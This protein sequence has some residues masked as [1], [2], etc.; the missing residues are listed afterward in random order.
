MQRG[1]K[2]SVKRHSRNVLQTTKK[3]FNLI[4][5][6][7]DTILSTEHWNSKNSKP[8]GLHGKSKDSIRLITQL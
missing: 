3:S 4:N 5:S 1:T 6:K 8:R 7:N 2:E